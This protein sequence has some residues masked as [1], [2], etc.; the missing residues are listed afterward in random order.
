MTVDVEREA[1]FARSYAF[2]QRMARP[3]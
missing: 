3:S 1:I 2:I